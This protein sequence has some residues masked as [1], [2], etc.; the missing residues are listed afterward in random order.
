MCLSNLIKD[1]G[2]AVAWVVA[3]IGWM[4]ANAQANTRERRKEVRSEIDE[5]AKHLQEALRGLNKYHH[6][7][8]SDEEAEK[9]TL[10]IKVSFMEIDSRI[11]RLEQRKG[12]FR[13]KPLLAL[14]KAKAASTLFFDEAT[15]GDFES[16]NK[17]A[18]TPANASKRLYKQ[19]HF[20]L[21]LLNELH[22]AFLK[23][24]R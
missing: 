21:R 5:I 1:Y 12:W 22:K 16:S 17:P 9:A 7:A 6:L 10:T 2:P 23:E 8:G 4:V 18:L 13:I 19:S 14:D 3:G 24:F 20:S 15:G 11:G